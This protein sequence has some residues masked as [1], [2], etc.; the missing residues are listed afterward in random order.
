[1]SQLTKPQLRA[2][3]MLSL[4][5]LII[6]IVNTLY[7]EYRLTGG[8]I[9][10]MDPQDAI[11]LDSILAL[12]PPEKEPYR[13]DPGNKPGT[14]FNSFAGSK[15]KIPINLHD[16]DPNSVSK[17]DWVGMGLPEKVF[18]GLEK[19]REK[20][21][22]IRKPEQVLK[23]YNLNPTIASQMLPFVKIDSL[24]LVSKPAFAKKEFKPYKPKPIE[25]LFDLNQADTTQLM[26]VFGIGGRTANRIL[27]YRNSVGGFLQKDQIYEVWGLDSAVVDELFK[28][29]YLPATPTVQKLLINQLSEE[30][31]ALNPYIRKG[32]ARIIVKYRIQH[33]PFH[34]ESDLLKIKILKPEVVAKI[35]PYLEF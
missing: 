33:G 5:T 20:G 8:Q 10:K 3:I 28:K 23:L 30:E 32:M 2:T 9:S 12:L 18:N 19:Y 4:A 1:M 14:E 24:N 13:S 21:G 6:L 26:K 22:R 35:S 34:S 7:N 11:I 16:F 15:K 27:K 17:A 31:L 29:A 25:P